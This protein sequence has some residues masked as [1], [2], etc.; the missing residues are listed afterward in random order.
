MS[1]IVLHLL[2][3]LIHSLAICY[4]LCKF[5]PIYQT[6]CNSLD[7]AD[8]CGS[9][10]KKKKKFSIIGIDVNFCEN[11]LLPLVTGKFIFSGNVAYECFRTD[12]SFGEIKRSETA[13]ARLLEFM[14][15]GPG[16]V[17]IFT[18]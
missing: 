16:V 5:M 2:S 14:P 1:C 8:D 6:F 4:I 11:E 9:V 7:G 10:G 3:V 15:L 12:L 18:Q 13:E 17:S